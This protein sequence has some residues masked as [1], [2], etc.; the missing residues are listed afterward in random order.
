MKKND[1]EKKKPLSDIADSMERWFLV[2]FVLLCLFGLYHGAKDLFSFTTEYFD[3]LDKK[4]SRKAL[5]AEE[6]SNVKNE[7]AAKKLYKACMDR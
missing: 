1:N 2:A 7:L 3:K 4:D 6:I 5:C